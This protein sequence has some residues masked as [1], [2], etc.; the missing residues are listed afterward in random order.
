MSTFADTLD[1]LERSVS[2]KNTA[3]NTIPAPATLQLEPK[4]FSAD[5]EARPKAVVLLGYKV[6]CEVE[7]QS[8][9]AE[10]MRRAW[11]LYEQP[12]DVDSRIECYNDSLVTLV[13]CRAICDPNDVNQMHPLLEMPDE[14]VPLAFPPA[15]IRHIFDAVEKLQIEQSPAYTEAKP[16]ELT[17]L[18][19]R[20]QRGDLDKLPIAAARRARRFLNFV[21]E[22]LLTIDAGS[23]QDQ[24]R[25]RA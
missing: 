25:R 7:M 19:V 5:W 1:Q 13:V 12:S 10:S 6:P 22:E 3:R 17:D 4:A 20:V 23:D 8:A 18:I 2:P 11:E 24:S 14:I 15:T 16:E 9:Q 21:L